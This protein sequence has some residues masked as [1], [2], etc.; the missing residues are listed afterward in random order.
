MSYYVGP[1]VVNLT[2][3]IVL[4]W[5]THWIVRRIFPEF[6]SDSSLNVSGR[7]LQAVAFSVVGIW[8]IVTAAPTAAGLAVA[9][10]S[11][12]TRGTSVYTQNVIPEITRLVVQFTAGV[13]LFA[14]AKALSA[15]WH[16]L[17][18]AGVSYPPGSPAPDPTAA[19]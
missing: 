12:A 11:G 6:T 16:R 8:M 7:D 17:R 4:L 2:A 18:Y 3:G 13:L 9:W 1:G 10:W 5:R 19:K 14:R 15:L